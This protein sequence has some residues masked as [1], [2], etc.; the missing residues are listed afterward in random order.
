MKNA[1]FVLFLFL[2]GST[3]AQAYGGAGSSGG[4]GNGGDNGIQVSEQRD[5]YQVTCANGRTGN[6]T[7]ANI[8]D[9]AQLMRAAADFCIE[10]EL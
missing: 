1:L 8:L 4:G 5:F 10:T 7:K 2:V 9:E 3:A 6:L